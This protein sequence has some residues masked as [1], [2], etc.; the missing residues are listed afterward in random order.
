MKQIKQS[1]WNKAT[2]AFGKLDLLIKG[3]DKYLNEDFQMC[4][5]RIRLQGRRGSDA[6]WRM[7]NHFLK[8]ELGVRLP[9]RGK[10][11]KSHIPGKVERRGCPNVP[12]SRS[13]PHCSHC[14]LHGVHHSAHED[15]PDCYPRI[16]SEEE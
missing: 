2:E 7:L 1:D 10:E 9:P 11:S 16:L 5:K 6:A 15:E 13:S 4:L 12:C 14:G 3:E 8:E